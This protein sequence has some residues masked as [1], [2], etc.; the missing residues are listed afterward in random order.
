MKR[1]S[2]A[3]GRRPR[4]AL[5]LAALVL[6]GCRAS[7]GAPR[8]GPADGG[9]LSEASAPEGGA[10]DVHSPDDVTP[11]IEASRPSD[12]PGGMQDAG[13]A[14]ADAW[15][16]GPP[17]AC[18]APHDGGAAPRLLGALSSFGGFR[19]EDRPVQGLAALLSADRVVFVDGPVGGV[20]GSALSLV[21]VGSDGLELADRALS[22]IALE[23]DPVGAFD[24]A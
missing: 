6:A 20:S 17:V 21:R 4:T 13:P 2:S 11:S 1:T 7:N 3:P 12:G 15:A 19:G 16:E 24:W 18:A 14:P 10:S 23:V 8:P 22:I 9:T 5:A